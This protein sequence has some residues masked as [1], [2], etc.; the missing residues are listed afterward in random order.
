MVNSFVATGL[1]QGLQYFWRVAT[2][3]ACGEGAFSA[4]FNFIANAETVL[5]VDQD[6]NAPDERTF[7]TDT[8]DALAISYKIFDATA[9]RPTAVEMAGHPMVIWFT[10]DLALGPN[11]AEAAE[12]ATYIDGGGKLFL[13]SEDYLWPFRPDVPPF[14]MN[15]LGIDTVV[16][17]GGDYTSVSPV[18]GSIFDGLPTSTLVYPAGLSDFSDHVTANGNGVLSLIGNNGNGAAIV[19]DDTVF[20]AFPFSTIANNGTRITSTEAQDILSAIVDHLINLEACALSDLDVDAGKD[21]EVCDDF[22]LQAMATGGTGPGT[23]SYSW[24][25]AGLLDDPTSATP[26]GTLTE[27]TTFTVTV[28]D[29]DS[30]IVIDSITLTY[31]PQYDVSLLEFWLTGVGADVDGNG[32]VDARD[33]VILID[34]LA[35]CQIPK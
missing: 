11:N 28:T 30:C 3:N 1:T 17:D 10:G 12:L 27:N 8:L 24:E 32:I 19:T 18:A 15:Y 21:E 23:Y 25:P 13:A 16:N 14:G 2:I 29:Q 35:D 7:F 6:N 4:A 34:N 26:S 31:R 33:Y 20:F 5:L 22:T 9:V